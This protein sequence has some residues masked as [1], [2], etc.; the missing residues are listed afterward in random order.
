MSLVDRCAEL[1][2]ARF[3][4]RAADYDA[5]AE[6]P[7]E[8]Y[9]DLHAAGLLG[10]TVPRQYGGVGADPRTYALCLLEIAK[11]CS[12]TALTFNMH[13]TVKSIVNTIASLEQKERYF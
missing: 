13:S 8:N 11:G 7:L 4:P 12:A 5:R 6:F 1:A 9:R 2:R 10:L 3:A